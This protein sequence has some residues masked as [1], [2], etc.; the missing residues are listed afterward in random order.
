MPR[1]GEGC[2]SIFEI[3]LNFSASSSISALEFIFLIS[4]GASRSYFRFQKYFRSRGPINYRNQRLPGRVAVV[5]KQLL[6][7]FWWRRGWT[8]GAWGKGPKS[9]LIGRFR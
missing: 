4:R 2:N 8:R 5:H 1:R 6:S 9:F 7:G 3:P